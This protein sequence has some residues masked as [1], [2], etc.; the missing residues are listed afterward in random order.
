MH[1]VVLVDKIKRGVYNEDKSIMILPCAEFS[2]KYR[3]RNEVM[4]MS[5]KISQYKGILV[6]IPDKVYET[7]IESISKAAAKIADAIEAKKS[8]YCF[9]PTHAGIFT[10][11][12]VYR[13]GGLAVINPIH[14]AGLLPNARPM[15]ITTSTERIPGYA[16]VILKHSGMKVGD[17][18]MVHSISGRIPLP[19]EMAIEARKKGIFVIGIVNLD[20]ATRM[21]SLDPSGKNLHQVCDI[22]IDNCGELGDACISM[23]NTPQKI[24]STSTVSGAF[25]ANSI[26]IKVCEILVEKGIEPPVLR[27]GNLDGAEEFNYALFEKHKDVIHYL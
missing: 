11:E 9:G 16:S 25:I 8:I 10:E 24:A 17:V 18:L 20:F 19:I 5:E 21:P 22:V 4:S 13:A 14:A 6:D 12:L 7:Q 1:N 15:T 23:E 27:S 26:V 3:T 2:R